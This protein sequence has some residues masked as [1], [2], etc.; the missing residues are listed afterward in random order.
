MQ[1]VTYPLLTMG[2]FRSL[3]MLKTIF[4]CQILRVMQKKYHCTR[5]IYDQ[6]FA[7]KESRSI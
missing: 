1:Y 3:L 2:C 5:H 7:K 4:N 6:L